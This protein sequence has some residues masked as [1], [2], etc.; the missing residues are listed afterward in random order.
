[1]DAIAQLEAL[2]KTA[3]EICGDAA[4]GEGLYDGLPTVLQARLFLLKQRCRMLG[5]ELTKPSQKDRMNIGKPRHDTGKAWLAG[6]DSEKEIFRTAKNGKVYKLNTETGETSGLGPEIDGSNAETVDLNVKPQV[7]HKKL[8]NI[9][10]DIYRGQDSEIVIGNGTTMDAVRHEL[11]TGQKV[12]KKYHSTKA[13]RSINGLNNC[14]RSGKLGA[15]E[16]K[17][18]KAIIEDLQ[19][20]LAGQ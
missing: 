13:Q 9:V 11:R 18:A 15:S 5:I 16:A 14:L 3:A 17:I 2:K 6:A 4:A 1:M 20:A 7:T 12:G 19:S 8:Q 10:S